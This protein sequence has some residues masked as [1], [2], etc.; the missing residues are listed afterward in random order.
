MIR[1]AIPIKE[2]HVDICRCVIPTMKS[3]LGKTKETKIDSGGD[4]YSHI[5]EVWYIPARSQ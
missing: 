5:F 3:E 4:A 2:R 1:E